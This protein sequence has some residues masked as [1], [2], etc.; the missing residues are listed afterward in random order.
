[1]IY[2]LAEA[3]AVAREHGTLSFNKVFKKIFL[4]MLLVQQIFKGFK[5][6][7]TFIVFSASK[8]ILITN[9]NCISMAAIH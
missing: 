7:A 8:E 3:C 2:C 6:E 9:S 4:M 5:F 1:M